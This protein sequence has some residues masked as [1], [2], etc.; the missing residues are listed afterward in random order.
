MLGE[1]E[2]CEMPAIIYEDMIKKVRGLE[3]E[4]IYEDEGFS[5]MIMRAIAKKKLEKRTFDMLTI[6]GMPEVLLTLAENEKLD[7]GMYNK[8]YNMN[9]RLASRL[10]ANGSIS[11][12]L[13][14]I[15]YDESGIQ[16]VK[17]LPTWKKALESI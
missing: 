7:I 15:I 14:V 5:S 16:D 3:G 1:H 9:K 10:A 12:E 4:G 2:E 13:A 6:C 8:L 17:N 11:A